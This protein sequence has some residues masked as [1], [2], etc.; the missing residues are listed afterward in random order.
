MKNKQ[1]VI[2]IL[3]GVVIAAGAFYTGTKV[4]GGR[5]GN[6]Q[7]RVIGN[8]QGVRGQFGQQGG[9]QG[10]W[11]VNGKIIKRDE[12]SITVELAD[13]SSKI[14]LLTE[15]SAINK[16]T[17]GA[18]DDLTEGTEVIVFGAANSDGSITAQNIQVGA[19]FLRR[20]GQP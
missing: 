1:L 3:I 14:I 16:T 8:A 19:V 9:V 10:L 18:R 13:G 2:A 20:D 5:A 4:R 6:F 7:G 12:T 11:P 15:T 17:E